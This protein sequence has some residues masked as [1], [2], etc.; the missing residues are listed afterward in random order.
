M[1]TVFAELKYDEISQI[2]NLLYHTLM[3][4]LLIEN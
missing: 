3:D 2:I 4:S 1:Q